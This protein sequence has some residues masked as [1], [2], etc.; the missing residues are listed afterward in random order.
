MSD[1]KCPYCQAE[2][3]IDHDDGYG[4]DEDTLHQQQCCECEKTFGYTTAIH[5][6]YTPRLLPCAN[7]ENHDMKP[8]IHFPNQWPD[9]VRCECGHEVRGDYRAKPAPQPESNATQPEK[10]SA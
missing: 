7:G 5:F 4:Y 6:H 2:N 3:E 9:W 10:V 8:V 1:I